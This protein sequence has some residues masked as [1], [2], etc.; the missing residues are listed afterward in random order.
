MYVMSD[1]VGRKSELK[2]LQELSELD[3][4]SIA[5]IKGRRRIGKSRLAE[6]FGRGKIFLSFSGIAPIQGVTAQDQRDAF[7]RQLATLFQ[8]PPL[9][10]TDWSDAFAHLSLRLT[11]QPTVILLDEISWM[12]AN[13]PTFVPK[14]KVWWDL[15]L[16]K[17]PHVVL[18]FCGS[19]SIWI[20]KNIINSTAFFGR[21]SLYIELEELTLSESRALLNRSGDF[22]SELDI[23][24]ILSVTGGIPWYLEQIYPRHNA[25]ENIKR[26]CFQKNGLLVTEFQRIFCDLFEKRGEIYQQITRSLIDGMKDLATIRKAIGYSSSGSLGEYLRAL[27]TSGYITKHPS[28]KIKTGQTSKTTLYRLSDNYLRF[29]LHY[30]EPNQSKIEKNSFSELP[31]SSLPGWEVMM[32]FQLENLLLKN[33]RLVLKALGISLQDVLADNPYVQKPTSQQKG[34]QIDYLIQTNSRTIY[35]C[36]IKMRR[37]EIGLEVIE[38]VKEKIRRLSIPKGFGIC[39]V[40]LH[41]GPASDALLNSRYFYRIIDISDF[42]DYDVP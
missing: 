25:D 31:L 35:I 28:W 15:V 3:R 30:I 14:L 37:K 22:R 21:I 5:V 32:G 24:K 20:D 29:Y 1:F 4:A 8:L 6:E 33:R 27:E 38:N 26:L 2:Q 16:Q 13:D 41:L 9:T 34:C 10:F 23:F 17:Y 19:V 40:L 18:I 7:G 12:S 39:P 11:S 42:L 36:E